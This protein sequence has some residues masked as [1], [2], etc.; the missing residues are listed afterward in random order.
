MVAAGV[1]DPVVEAVEAAG[2]GGG[3]GGNEASGDARRP[4]AV[5][6]SAVVIASK[7]RIAVRAWLGLGLRLGL[8]LG[9]GSGSGSG[10]RCGARVGTKHHL[11]AL[12]LVHAGH[13]HEARRHAAVQVTHALAQDEAAARARW[14]ARC[15]RVVRPPLVVLG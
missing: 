3:G 10:L 13:M 7:A 12:G 15:G 8:G 6:T 4:S 14:H 9:L 2:D 11:V 5:G 1:K